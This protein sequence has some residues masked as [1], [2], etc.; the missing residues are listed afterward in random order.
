MKPSNLLLAVVTL[1]LLVRAVN[2]KDLAAVNVNTA[3]ADSM[4]L[5]LPGVGP[6]VA[7]RVVENR[8]YKSCDDL[9][10][11]VPG[12]GEKKIAKICPLVRF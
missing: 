1:S 3:P 7:Q 6:A 11:T 12:I 9:K 10:N 4:A 2:G 5:H 8:P